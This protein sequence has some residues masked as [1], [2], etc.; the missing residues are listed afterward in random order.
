MKKS[1]SL[2]NV[3]L[4]KK[5]F[6]AFL[7]VIVPIYLL[8]VEMITIEK[9]KV[10]KEIV[11]SAYSKL[12]LYLIFMEN[13]FYN[14]RKLE[15]KL[16]IDRDILKLSRIVGLPNNY[17]EYSSYYSLQDKLKDIEDI[18]KYVVAAKVYIMSQGKEISPG[19]IK[20]YS[21][22]DIAKLKKAITDKSY[23]FAY[24]DDRIYIII[25]PYY[26]YPN[27]GAYINPKFI[28]SVEVSEIKMK[29]ELKEFFNTEQGEALLLGNTN[30]LSLTNKGDENIIPV[31]RNYLAKNGD[32]TNSH[33]IDS[34]NVGK[35]DFIINIK[36][37]ETLNSLLVILVNKEKFFNLLGMYSNWIWF[38]SLLTLVTVIIFSLWIKSIVI[39][40]IDKLIGVFKKVET[41][42]SV[43]YV[44]YKNDDE[45][46]YLYKSFVTTHPMAI[47]LIM[48]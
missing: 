38:I 5:I 34:M 12:D 47:N 8:S 27:E 1:L 15:D 25:T 45:F 33:K 26:L 17:D 9:N 11:E 14:I 36:K 10:R 42:E 22:T 16:I 41:G 43:I 31:L 39:K 30:G 40:P 20:D 24:I 23:P 7:I 4:F 35:Q 46:G 13:E 2:K 6:I 29:K 32:E 37:S 3:S 44:E 21:N 28:I 19:Q 18:S 48:Q